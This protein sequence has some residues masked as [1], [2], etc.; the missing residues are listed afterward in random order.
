MNFFLLQMVGSLPGRLVG[1][2]TWEDCIEYAVKIVSE[3]DKDFDREDL[4]S[5]LEDGEYSNSK[6]GGCL[7]ILCN[8]DF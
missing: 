7:Y 5:S 3:H 6:V 1:P 2:G 4:E 8:E